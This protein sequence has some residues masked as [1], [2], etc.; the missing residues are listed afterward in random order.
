ME[1]YESG[2]SK[3]ATDLLLDLEFGEEEKSTRQYAV[4]CCNL[5]AALAES[6]NYQLAIKY[7][8]EAEEFHKKRE[9]WADLS[10]IYFNL[11]NV[12]KYIG[13]IPIALHYYSLS[14]ECLD[15]ID[16][17]RMQVIVSLAAAD[18]HAQ[19]GDFESVKHCL[20]KIDKLIPYLN[21]IDGEIEFSLY[22]VK[23]KMAHA[24]GNSEQSIKYFEAVVDSARKTNNLSYL[25]EAFKLLGNAQYSNNNYK[26]ALEHLSQAKRIM[27]SIGDFRTTAI[28][29]VMA[30]CL[31]QLGRDDDA[32]ELLSHRSEHHDQTLQQ[33]KTEQHE[34]RKFTCEIF[35]CP[36]VKNDKPHFLSIL[37]HQLDSAGG[38][39]CVFHQ[40]DAYLAV[41]PSAGSIIEINTNEPDLDNFLRE[42]W[43]NQE[44][45]DALS[46]IAPAVVQAGI[47]QRE[48]N[49]FYNSMIAYYFGLQVALLNE[50]YQGIEIIVDN[51]YLLNRA[52]RSEFK[53]NAT[54]LFS[55]SRRTDDREKE[56]EKILQDLG[57]LAQRL[58]GPVEGML[59]K[60][61]RNSD[62]QA[63]SNMLLTIR[64][65][66]AIEN[67]DRSL[68]QQ[69]LPGWAGGGV[70]GPRPTEADHKRRALIT[71]I[72]S[73]AKVSNESIPF[74]QS[75]YEELSQVYI[76]EVMEYLSF[77]TTPSKQISESLEIQYSADPDQDFGFHYLWELYKLNRL[78]FPHWKSKDL[79]TSCSLAVDQFE[80]L[81]SLAVHSG[82]GTGHALSYA[83]VQ[84]LGNLS[85]DLIKFLIEQEQPYLALQAAEQ[86]CSRAMVDWMGRTHSNNR[87]L[88]REGFN[89]SI[90]E[91]SVASLDEIARAAT[92]SK[93]PIL[94]YIKIFDE[95]IVWFVSPRGELIWEKIKYPQEL[96]NQL[97]ELLPYEIDTFY[98]KGSRYNFDSFFLDFSNPIKIDQ[99]LDNLGKHLIPPSIY[100]ALKEFQQNDLIIITDSELN[101]VPYACLRIN[102][103][104]LVEHFNLVYWPSVTAW[105][106][107]DGQ[108]QHWEGDQRTPLSA[109]V[110]GD[111]TYKKS[112]TLSAQDSDLSYKL[113]R[114]PG[115]AQEA[116]A[117]AKLLRVSPLLEESA[118]FTKLM[119]N[120]ELNY[121]QVGHQAFIPVIHLAAHGI[122]SVTEPENSFIALSDGPLTAGY[123][124]RYDPGIRCKLVVLSSCQTALGALH[125]DS[126]I[127]LTNAFLIAGACSVVSTLWK[128]PDDVTQEL[129]I[130][131][132][133]ELE[134][135][136]SLSMAMSKAQRKILIKEKWKHPFF[137]GSFKIT[138]SN[139]NPL[140]A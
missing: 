131:F 57:N 119:E 77:P 13:I 102:D 56:I 6:G 111:P 112:L 107:C 97:F 85:R 16:H 67:Q 39:L 43:L 74:F 100:Q 126:L 14:L 20:I 61:I 87:L 72:G 76:S 105:I 15:Q 40:D 70:I 109:I 108:I 55:D 82:T 4:Y 30:V 2:F 64:R 118:S 12:N 8:S 53:G 96:I 46:Q 36:G 114:L 103:H 132:Y 3:E 51:L 69:V 24:E 140:T 27:E 106:L 120:Y 9:E 135:G 115:T 98:D 19:N 68:E 60:S 116:Q 41:V 99:V 1:L 138:G 10:L 90:G 104:Y 95:V 73:I 79:L 62:R 123:L 78:Y 42:C 49:N 34:K 113:E 52:I 92:E 35:Y 7:F 59:S 125:P 31:F 101:Y 63:R 81:R 127:G 47:E 133:E 124:Y 5:G 48:Q 44:I 37:E 129:V 18:L 54:L 50:D 86:T 136:A 91:I 22:S 29:E 45:V 21:K 75:I 122:L 17:R 23:A 93:S 83:I 11:G 32:K 26:V 33:A 88:M 28:D 94:Y 128:I 80:K 65:I 137:W 130:S 117:V 139:A 110:L 84:F 134:N 38:I 121:D 71:E 89:G 66:L 58:I 25:A